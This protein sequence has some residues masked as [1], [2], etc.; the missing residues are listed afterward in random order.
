MEFV[1]L[2]V[3][4]FVFILVVGLVSN[5]MQNT[6]KK[7][8]ERQRQLEEERE[9]QKKR[10]LEKI[11][12]DE[13]WKTLLENREHEFG[14]L[15]KVVK[16]RYQRENQ[17]YVYEQT[18][19]LFIDGNKYAFSDILSCEV[20]RI[21]TAGKVQEFTT[22]PDKGEMATQEVLYGMG[23][24]YNVKTTTKVVTTPEKVKYKVYI[25]LNSISTPQI[26]FE[27]S[28]GEVANEVKSLMNAIANNK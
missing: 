21:V 28:S 4:F 5:I 6:P 17:I 27:L 1:V 7:K 23:K 9:R 18:K 20:E 13:E 10:E 8:A 26:T 25:G 2:I 16:I 24:K 3:V 14:V 22:T 11:K 19:T 15:T 12:K